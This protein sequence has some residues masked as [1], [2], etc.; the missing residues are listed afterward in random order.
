[1]SSSSSSALAG[2]NVKRHLLPSRRFAREQRWHFYILVMCPLILVA[3]GFF[4]LPAGWLELRWLLLWLVMWWLVGCLGVSVGLHRLFSHR[5][6]KCSDRV[7]YFLG[8][9]GSMACQGNVTYWVALHRCHHSLSDCPGDPHSPST[10]ARPGMSALKAFWKGHIGWVYLHDVP[11][12]ARYVPEMVNNATDR[13]LA[14]HYWYW[15]VMGIFL[16]AVIGFLLDRSL[17]GI[18]LGA[19]WGGVF[20]ISLGQQIIWSINSVC[21]TFGNQATITNDSSRNNIWLSIISWGESWHNNHHAQPASARLGSSALQIDI[22]WWCLRIM[23]T[24]GIIQE[25]RERRV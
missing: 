2:N 18:I 12:P 17:N 15:V 16:P 5:T 24:L 22:G 20:R 3:T 23:Q 10:N 8:A 6:F 7:R 4:F 19:W 21:H 11:S 9:L 1:M 25:V 13:S 14:N